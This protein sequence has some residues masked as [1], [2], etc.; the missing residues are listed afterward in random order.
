MRSSATFFEEQRRN[1]VI[2][3]VL[4]YFS[5]KPRET[6]ADPPRD[7]AEEIIKKPLKMEKKL[8]VTQRKPREFSQRLASP[9]PGAYNLPILSKKP[10]GTA[11]I[12][13]PLAKD[14][15]GSYFRRDLGPGPADYQRL[16][17]FSQG[18]GVKFPT[19]VRENQG[20]TKKKGS[21]GPADYCCK[22]E[23][24][25]N[26]FFSRSP[27]FSFKKAKVTRGI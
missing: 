1:H 12:G 15:H 21:P 22:R 13:F 7:S 8:I 18:K 17:E 27:A 24:A 5:E 2:Q 25:N 23:V 10:R 6:P 26:R 19:A 20:N 3:R 14:S 16:R 11:G 4:C 9:G